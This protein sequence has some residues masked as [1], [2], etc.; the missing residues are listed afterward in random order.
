MIELTILQFL[1]D[2]RD[3]PCIDHGNIMYQAKDKNYS[4]CDKDLIELISDGLVEK[5][6]LG[7]YFITAVGIAY[8]EEY[9]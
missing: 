2:N 7:F 8:L 1:D 9:S 5:D 6:E 4:Q 3:S